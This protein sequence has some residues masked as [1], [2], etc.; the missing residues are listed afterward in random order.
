MHPEALSYL[1]KIMRLCDEHGVRVVWIASPYPM[2]VL[3]QGDYGEE[4]ATIRRL[5]EGYG[6][7]YWNFNLARPEALSLEL[8]DFSDSSHL[9]LDG[10]N[11]LTA[12]FAE[13]IAAEREGKDISGSF[14]ASFAERMEAEG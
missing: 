7:P 3:R 13:L 12:L 10:A 9:N 2:E 11:K 6:V 1:D 4:D 14:Y 8:S 5:A